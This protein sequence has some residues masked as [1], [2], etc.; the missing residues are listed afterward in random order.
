MKIRLTRRELNRICSQSLG[1]DVTWVTIAKEPVI[2]S[3]ALNILTALHKEFDNDGVSVLLCNGAN[4]IPL[5]KFIRTQVP[6]MGLADAKWA[7][8]HWDEW[9][10]FVYKNN[11]FPIITYHTS[12]WP[13][14]VNKLS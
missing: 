6:N 10:E 13:N 12:S 1:Q 9:Y 14:A 5:I 2:P 7:I 8:E 4:K 3:L 11:R